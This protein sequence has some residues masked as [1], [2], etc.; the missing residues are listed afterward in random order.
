MFVS[1][2]LVIG[3]YLVADDLERPLVTVPDSRAAVKSETEEQRHARH[4]QVAEARSNTVVIL[5]RGAWEYAPEN[6]LSAIRAGLELAR[7]ASN[8]ISVAPRTA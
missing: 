1:V 7:L 2:S 3:L 8:S 4:A 5:H 6:T